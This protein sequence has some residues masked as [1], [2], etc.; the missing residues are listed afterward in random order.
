LPYANNNGTN[1]YLKQKDTFQKSK[2]IYRKYDF[3]ERK[4]FF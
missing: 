3:A 2:E 4:L 1:K